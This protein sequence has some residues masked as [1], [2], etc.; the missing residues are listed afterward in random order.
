MKVR[1][2][3]DIFIDY[4]LYRKHNLEVPNISHSC[5]FDSGGVS[6]GHSNLMLGHRELIEHILMS[7]IL[8]LK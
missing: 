7:N 6:D 2:W 8:K 3:L 5:N 1:I 4:I